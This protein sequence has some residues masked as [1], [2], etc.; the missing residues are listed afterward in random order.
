MTHARRACLRLAAAGALLLCLP[1]GV[2]RAR[3]AEPTA[4]EILALADAV[5]NPAESYFAR[6]SVESSDDPDHPSVFD[7]MLLGSTR[8][9]VRTIEPARDRGRSLLMVGE[10][11]WAYVPSL[12]RAV[13][14]SLNQRLV[15][16]AANGDVARMRWSGDYAPTIE[17]SSERSWTL[18]LVAARKGLTYDRMR[19]T[20]E[21]GTFHPLSA[22]LLTLQ[23]KPLK[24]ATYRG[25]R[26]LC[27]R[28]RPTEME[29]RDALRGES[30]SVL[31]IVEM[32]VQ[33]FPESLFTPESL[34]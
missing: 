9:L 5:R 1:P 34:P 25:Y 7:V 3:A 20:I 22:E 18:S 6:L 15:G 14:V 17:S 31:R 30:V 8:T 23:G 16:Q 24:R 27:G 2:R 26:T 29:I 32:R 10:E 12:R 21:K 13:R 33:R 28:V 4:D 11:M 19:V